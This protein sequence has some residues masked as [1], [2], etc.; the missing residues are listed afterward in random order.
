MSDLRSYTSQ[1]RG[2]GSRCKEK[3]ETQRQHYESILHTY[4]IE[5]NERINSIQVE[6]N[7]ALSA[8]QRE[9]SSTKKQYEDVKEFNRRMNMERQV[10]KGVLERYAQEISEKSLAI[11]RLNERINKL[12]ETKQSEIAYIESLAEKRIFSQKKSVDDMLALKQKACDDAVQEARD[13]VQSLKSSMK[14][15]FNEEVGRLQ[16]RHEDRC[17]LIQ[18]EFEKRIKG[19]Q[20]DVATLRSRNAELEDKQKTSE[21]NCQLQLDN[22]NQLISHLKK[23][24]NELKAN[25]MLTE[26]EHK[27]V[28]DNLTLKYQK[29]YDN[30]KNVHDKVVAEKSVM[31]VDFNSLQEAYRNI[32]SSHTDEVRELRRIISK[33][34]TDHSESMKEQLRNTDKYRNECQN[35]SLDLQ[36]KLKTS[37]EERA[38]LSLRLR[39]LHDK[40]AKEIQDLRKSLHT[41]TDKHT[42][43]TKILNGKLDELVAKENENL[44]LLRRSD[45]QSKQINVYKIQIDKLESDLD[46][47]VNKCKFLTQELEHIQDQHN[48]ILKASSTPDE[49]ILVQELR[50]EISKLNE[51]IAKSKEERE[52]QSMLV[53]QNNAYKNST[54]L[55]KGKL[56]N[57]NRE[58]DNLTKQNEILNK[59]LEELK[60]KICEHENIVSRLNQEKFESNNEVKRLRKKY[61]EMEE[62]YRKLKSSQTLR[63]EKSTDYELKSVHLE[64][65]LVEVQ[66]ALSKL[67][68]EKI[69]TDT[70]A[71]KLRIELN[72]MITE[73]DNLNRTIQTQMNTIESVQAQYT[74]LRQSYDGIKSQL[75]SE[76]A[77]YDEVRHKLEDMMRSK[78]TEI[79]ALKRDICVNAGMVEKYNELQ[80]K[81]KNVSDTLKALQIE[82][83][84]LR[85]K[86]D[87]SI[88]L[89]KTENSELEVRVRQYNDKLSKRD[90]ENR[91]LSAELKVMMRYERQVRMLESQLSDVGV[92]RR[93]YE[94]VDMERS[95][96]SRLYKALVRE[97]DATKRH[98][99]DQQRIILDLQDTKSLVLQ[100]QMANKKLT[101]ANKDILC[102]VDIHKEDLAT[103]QNEVGQLKQVNK[104][105]N[106]KCMK[107]KENI[108]NV[109]IQLNKANVRH[110]EEVGKFQLIERELREE[111]KCLTQY[112][113]EL[114]KR[115]KGTDDLSMVNKSLQDTIHQLKD[116]IASNKAS[117]VVLVDRLRDLQHEYDI[118]K[119]SV[120]KQRYETL[121]EREKLMK[122]LERHEQA[123]EILKSEIKEAHMA[124]ESH[125]NIIKAHEERITELRRENGGMIDMCNKYKELVN[126]HDEMVAKYDELVKTHDILVV[127]LDTAQ[128]NMRRYKQNGIDN[129]GLKLRIKE[130]EESI[131]EL[132][133]N[134]EE[135]RGL[136]AKQANVF[137]TQ[138]VEQKELVKRLEFD[139]ARY[140]SRIS[141][142]MSQ[143]SGLESSEN[144]LKIQLRSLNGM[145]SKNMDD[146]KNYVPMTQYDKLVENLDILQKENAM[147]KSDIE[148]MKSNGVDGDK[149]KHQLMELQNNMKLKDE[150]IMRLSDELEKYK[151]NVKYVEKQLRDV[152]AIE[153]DLHK[154]R[155]YAKELE[156]NIEKY[157]KS[158]EILNVKSKQLRDTYTLTNKQNQDL[159]STICTLTAQL[160]SQREEYDKRLANVYMEMT[161]K[162]EHIE[163]AKDT[164][165]QSTLKGKKVKNE[166]QQ[167]QSRYDEL[168]DK[169]EETLNLLKH[170]L[171][172]ISILEGK[173]ELK[174]EHI[175]KL[176]ENMSTSN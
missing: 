115:I 4:E 6:Y 132:M 171:E 85:G 37:E 111:I 54:N 108:D 3:L 135:T 77:S 1:S 137:A 165:R 148:R 123:N 164:M 99:E 29:Q 50:I 126:V 92:I 34:N 158:I 118:Y 156:E 169:Y 95:K 172:Q 75:L 114:L 30:L 155:E 45:V 98:I 121:T 106:D 5:C 145:L 131:S 22:S 80:K 157:K 71:D 17:K 38:N 61:G 146:K 87:K 73:R 65:K 88:S 28:V 147:M 91:V 59:Q 133:S 141:E 26:K 66:T 18:E 84:S 10:E 32:N 144:E 107:L 56:K 76:K 142:Q 25:A 161:K 143:I 159:E 130:L 12:N 150:L 79:D 101:H 52:M 13:E 35:I 49:D 51:E 62:D 110:S 104:S 58:T 21:R 46:V 15:R 7:Q 162:D 83:D 124:V 47:Y 89:L 19:L 78:S 81:H 134:K 48:V 163:K 97:H 125:T 120:Q 96:Y 109:S 93:E 105:L 44:S 31:E 174:D 112:K 11:D 27:A 154:S 74:A 69:N 176:K 167:L 67:K 23:D 41:I 16:M 117:R 68:K 160:E 14:S 33:L 149:F 102:R 64:S 36:D 140:K 166:I 72:G 151:N 24:V 94:M 119:D 42:E 90:N 86:Y 40:S 63:V 82:L 100:L 57:K 9:L 103:Q 8:L 152:N 168:N 153:A 127:D 129:E 20:G 43:T 136:S 139:I 60:K 53:V 70:T 2:G 128:K 116:D 122:A 175:A 39:T 173:L 55:L 170:R 138:I 113:D